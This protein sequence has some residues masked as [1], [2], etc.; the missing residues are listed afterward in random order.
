MAR[1]AEVAL[2]TTDVPRMIEFYERLLG[3]APRSRSESH[4][5]FDVGETVIFIHL[6]T[7]DDVGHDAPG[8]DHV[9]I[10]VPDQDALSEQLRAQGHSV[11]GPKVYDW[12]RSAYVRDPD[13]RTIELVADS[14]DG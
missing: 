4:A 12:G 3:E 7:H 10:A 11:T 2:F 9:A 13:G 1:I 8:G 5:Y 6:V 14:A